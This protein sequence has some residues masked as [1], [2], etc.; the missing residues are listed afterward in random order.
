MRASGPAAEI[1]RGPPRDALIDCIVAPLSRTRL[2]IGFAIVVLTA[3]A[4]A[5]GWFLARRWQPVVT[6]TSTPAAAPPAMGKNPSGKTG[7]P[8]VP[9]PASRSAMPPAAAAMLN[10]LPRDGGLK[11]Q[12]AILAY[13]SSLDEAAAKALVMSY[14]GKG[15]PS[16]KNT[17]QLYE[18]VLSRWAE[19]DPESV[20][21]TARTTGDMRF[22]W[23]A[24]SAAFDV[25]GR[26]DPDQAWKRAGEMGVFKEDAQRAVI[27][28]LSSQDPAAAFAMASKLDSPQGQWALSSVMR[29]WADRDPAG[30]AAAAV[31]LPIGQMRTKALNGLMERWAINDYGAAASWA[32]SL[33][34]PQ[35]RAS[36][37][38][39]ALSSLSQI[40]PEKSLSLLDSTDVGNGRYNIINNAIGSLALRD[41]DGAMARATSFTNFTDK[42][43]ALSALA[44]SAS[45]EDRP[46]LLKLAESL[47]ANLSRSIYQGNIWQRMYSDPAGMADFVQ[48]IPLASVRED[49]MKMAAENLGYY[50][51]EAAADLFGKLQ[52]SSQTSD[53][54]ASIAGRLAQ[55]NPEKALAWAQQL[56]TEA[57][58]KSALSSAIQAWAA[59]EPEK[60]GQEI[61]KIESAD[62][63]AEVARSVAKAMAGR[64]LTEAE[65]WVA[66]LS[67]ADR[68]AALGTVVEQA[69]RQ[70]P[71]RVETL[72]SSF[73]SALSPEMAARSENQA[74]AR[75]VASQLAQTDATRASSWA[76]S[77]P[78]GG[79]RD[80]A[81]AGVVSTWAG[82]DAHAASEW[83]HEVP[84][85]KGRDLAAGNLVNT[86]ARDD[87]ESAWAWATSIGD[88]ARR[89]EAAA[90]ALAGWKANGNREA[91][92]AALDAGGFS[93]EEYRELARKLE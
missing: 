85:G 82:Y 40:D 11:N 78:E 71:D 69:A 22:R 57:L 12:A 35:E 7:K 93:P 46:K 27:Y 2:R 45:D 60:A 44:E 25:L 91:A 53:T 90:A 52:T 70:A 17:S 59:T 58:R 16:D 32:G 19:L 56:G 83:L 29:A 31:Q 38:S 14:E 51:P 41:F 18:A 87:P 75:T 84:A 13:A 24:M 28:R 23:N 39:S 62:T 5:G 65:G 64:S 48:K 15:Y 26:R 9:E 76:L 50:Q 55:T 80:E 6:I 74:V 81:V 30:A 34:S 20:I 49:A 77:L 1:E 86:I 67:G 63:R 10:A 61:A 47:P 92:Q 73:A 3:S 4:F 43:G 36:A 68:S 37:M 8:A 79:A 89:R 66:T 72:Y 21:R 88:N 33:K 54:A 42:T